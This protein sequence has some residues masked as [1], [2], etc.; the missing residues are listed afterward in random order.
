MSTVGYGLLPMCLLGVL[1]IFA[2]LNGMVGTVFGLALAGWCS[3]AAGNY[4]EALMKEPY[5]NRK[6]LIVYP[7]FLFYVSFAMIVMF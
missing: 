4:V 1:G 2:H 7:L 3:F 5:Q 6:L